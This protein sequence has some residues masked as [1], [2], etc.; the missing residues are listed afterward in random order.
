MLDL[1]DSLPKEDSESNLKADVSKAWTEMMGRFLPQKKQA[2][3]PGN[4]ALL[5]R[6]QHIVIV[7][8]NQVN[9]K[10]LAMAMVLNSVRQKSRC[11]KNVYKQLHKALSPYQDKY[12]W[13]HMP[14]QSIKLHGGIHVGKKILNHLQK[15]LVIQFNVKQRRNHSN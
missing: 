12:T 8:A 1:S 7:P 14:R 15:S 11:K 5:K 4:S 3:S 9:L 2:M 13:K 10:T 6:S